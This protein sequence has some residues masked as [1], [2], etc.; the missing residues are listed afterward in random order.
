[1]LDNS[2]CVSRAE[3]TS[4]I[5]QNPILWSKH[6]LLHHENLHQQQH[7]Q[8]Q[9]NIGHHNNDDQNKLR[10]IN[11]A[12]LQ[13]S[14]LASVSVSPPIAHDRNDVLTPERDEIIVGELM[15][16]H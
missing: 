10:I 5:Y 7:Q 8:N 9:A 2:R 6:M 3:L 11:T 15:R 13:K 4:M 12:M 14:P 1:M 16:T